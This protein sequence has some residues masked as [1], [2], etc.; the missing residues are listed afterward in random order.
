MIKLYNSLII[1]GPDFIGSNFIHY[2]FRISSAKI[3]LFNDAIIIE[4]NIL[5]FIN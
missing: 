3:N 1:G 2:F 4:D 5:D